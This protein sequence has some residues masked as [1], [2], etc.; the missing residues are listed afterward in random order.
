[1]IRS[2]TFIALLSIL[3]LMSAKSSSSKPDKK[4]KKAVQ[5]VIDKLFDSM[6]AGDGEGV[7]AV[8]TPDATLK[9]IFVKDGKPILHADGTVEKFATAVGTPHEKVWDERISSY[10]IQIDGNLASVWTPY[11]F[12]AG[13]TFSHCG[14]NAFQLFKSEN[15]WKIFHIADTRR[16]SDCL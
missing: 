16:Q 2:T 3:F 15:G 10:E 11:Q 13:D 12:Y 9:T 4:E 8:F 1:M 6:R 14:V 7:R 5:A